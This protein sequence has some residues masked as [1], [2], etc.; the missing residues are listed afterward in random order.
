MTSDSTKGFAGINGLISELDPAVI[1]ALQMQKPSSDGNNSSKTE[2]NP[3]QQSGG[4]ASPISTSGDKKWFWWI[5]LACAVLWLINLSNDRPKR[6]S[7][8]SYQSQTLDS[9]NYSPTTTSTPSKSTYTTTDQKPVYDN[10]EVD[11][12]T[13][14]S[15][16]TQPP[17]QEPPAPST[18]LPTYEPDVAPLPTKSKS[19]SFDCSKAK[20]T[21]E[22][23]ICSNVELSSLDGQV[24]EIYTALK[25]STSKDLELGKALLTEQKKF[26][27]DRSDACKIPVLAAIPDNEAAPMINCLKGLYSLRLSVL[28]N[29]VNIAIKAAKSST[30]IDPEAKSSIEAAIR[31]FSEVFK[32]TGVSGVLGFLNGDCAPQTAMEETRAIYCMAFD[33]IASGVLSAVE[34]KKH[35]PLTP[36]FQ[37]DAYNARMRLRLS[38]A[39]VNETEKQAGIIHGFQAE[40]YKALDRLEAEGNTGLGQ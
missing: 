39:G 8:R 27:K 23:L 5:V 26:L 31:K 14:P 4:H 20:A 30:N 36:Q 9:D 12:A 18:Q 29:Y 19:A 34:Q 2:K 17:Y 6:S 32:K 25:N 3:S 11:E 21:L 7:H 40:V 15:F 35:Y 37:D 16:N 13:P 22:T 24:G 38:K 1:S 10:N 33:T 28:Q